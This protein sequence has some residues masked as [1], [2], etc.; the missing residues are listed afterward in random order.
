MW[1]REM[2]YHMAHVYTHIYMVVEISIWI[3]RFYDPTCPKRSE[4]FK[5]LCDHS[6]SVGSLE[7]YDPTEG[8][9][10]PKWKIKSQ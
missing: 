3:L 6:E 5:N 7:S 1:E 10:G 9:V 2:N 4:S 8:S